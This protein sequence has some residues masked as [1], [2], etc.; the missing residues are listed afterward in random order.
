M[1]P[2]DRASHIHFH[3]EQ[4]SGF[5]LSHPFKD[6]GFPCCC[7][8]YPL[9]SVFLGVR[10]FAHAYGLHVESAEF[11]ASISVH[12]TRRVVDVKDRSGLYVMDKDCI[13]NRIKNRP[14]PVLTLLKLILRSFA[15]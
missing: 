10:R 1:P 9:D 2:N 4:T 8:L 5:V 11:L 15:P 3:P 6:L 12:V 13:I 14:E 7:L